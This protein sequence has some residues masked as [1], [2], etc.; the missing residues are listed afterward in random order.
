MEENKIMSYE[1]NRNCVSCKHRFGIHAAECCIDC[2]D[3]SNWEWRG[4]VDE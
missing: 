3:G 4:V 1:D 2:E